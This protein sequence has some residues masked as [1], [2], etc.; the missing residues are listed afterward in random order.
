PAGGRVRVPLMHQEQKFNYHDGGTFQMLE[1]PYKGRDLAMVVVLP[2]K[3]DGLAGLE[4]TLTADRLAA[5]LS[6]VRGPRVDVTLPAFKV[7]SESAL[8]RT[9]AALGMPNAFDSRAADFSGMNGKQDLF[10]QAVVHKAFVDVNE[11]G[12]E[13]AAATGVGVGLLSATPPPPRV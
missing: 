7:T 8:N 5:G 4:K 12:T 9:L 11:E 6:R 2:R 10:I 1:L 3:T 13:A